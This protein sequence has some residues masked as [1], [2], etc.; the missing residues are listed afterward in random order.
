MDR[1][2][3]SELLDKARA[4]IRNAD[5]LTD[6]QL[7]AELVLKAIRIAEDKRIYL[8]VAQGVMVA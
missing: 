2:L 5:R 8:G 7:N 4:E 6:D 1:T 3:L